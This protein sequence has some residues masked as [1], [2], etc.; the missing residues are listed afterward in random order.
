M[1]C[2]DYCDM[3]TLDRT[4]AKQSRAE[5]I[6]TIKIC[7]SSFMQLLA[8]LVEF[9]NFSYKAIGNLTAEAEA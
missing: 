6:L 9:E 8:T 5:L 4:W 3:I 1:V 7:N 2:Q